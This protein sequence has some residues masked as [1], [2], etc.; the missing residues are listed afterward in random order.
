MNTFFRNSLMMLAVGSLAVSCADYNVTDDF[1][2]APDPS[3]VEPFKSYNP[4]L[5]S[6]D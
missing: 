2:A 3:Y 1:R 4:G 6:E 5:L